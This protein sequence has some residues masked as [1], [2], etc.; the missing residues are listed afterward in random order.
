VYYIQN[1]DGA[2]IPE[3]ADTLTIVDT[4]GIKYTFTKDSDEASKSMFAIFDTM[5]SGAESRATLPDV[6]STSPYFTVIY[7]IDSRRTEYQ[8]YL[9]KGADNAYFLDSTGGVYQ[10]KADDAKVFLDTEYAQNVHAG[11]KCPALI[12]S[13]NHSVAPKTARWLYKN[14]TGN[15][16]EANVSSFIATTDQIFDLDGGI[17]LEFSS[18]PD[19]A[20]VV[21]TDKDGNSIYN[22]TFANISSLRVEGG[23][24]VNVTIDAH[25]YENDERAFFGDLSY[26][27]SATVSDSAEF[28]PGVNSITAGEFISITGLH[29]KDP[30]KITFS[31]EPDIG[32]TPTFVTDEAD[33]KYVRALIPFGLNLTPGT[34]SLTLGYAGISQT[35]NID[36]AARVINT[37]EYDIDAALVTTYYTDSAKTAFHTETDAIA[38]KIT[39]K[40]QWDGYFLQNET[41][42]AQLTMGFGHVRTVAAAGISFNNPGVSYAAGVGTDIPAA[43]GG[44]VVFSG[45]LEISGYTVIIDH[46]FG[47]KT[48]YFHMSENTVKVGDVVARGDTIG[49]AGATGFT[50]Q[51][52]VCVAMSVCDVFVSP[53]AT[54]VDGLW[55][56]VPVYKEQ[57]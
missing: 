27:F 25:W 18:V 23:V 50:N 56:D 10:V 54:W 8:Y 40:A 57:Q 28:Y 31:S 44:T 30:S 29:V 45:I 49:K 16:V 46:G 15:F 48:W 2:L 38:K 39:P 7:S 47:L 24:T 33:P 34:Y 35:I 12:L 19:N 26:S 1:K 13:G 55:A 5:Y 37:R 20:S 11:S 51:N 53:Y 3:V 52:G 4:E 41:I 9:S 42:N 21:V 17:S 36:V 43:N 6:V 22:D 32:F 14:S